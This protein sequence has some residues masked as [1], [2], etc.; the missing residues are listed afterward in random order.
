[1]QK[2]EILI[3]LNI[4]NE[5]SLRAKFGANPPLSFGDKRVVS[6]EDDMIIIRDS[7]WEIYLD[8]QS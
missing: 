4:D 6:F 1:M 5:D 2:D 8:T 7:G 3:Y